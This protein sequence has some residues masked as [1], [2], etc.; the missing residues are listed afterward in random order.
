MVRLRRIVHI[1]SEKYNSHK[2]LG[3]I[4]GSILKINQTESEM[5]HAPKMSTAE[6]RIDFATM[7]ALEVHN[8]CRAF[9]GWP[10]VWSQFS[11]GNITYAL[12]M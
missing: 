1:H 12:L 3:V 9:D 4:L 6:S 8:R 7:S 10:G 11:L 5:T 2:F